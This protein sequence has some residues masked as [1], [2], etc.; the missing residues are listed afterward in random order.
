ML[1]LPLENVRNHSGTGLLAGLVQ[2]GVDVGG[3]G[4]IRVPQVIG[5]VDEGHVLADEQAGEGVPQV[6]EADVPQAVLLQQ[7]PEVVGRCV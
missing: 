7:L 6:V 4:Q 1:V 5:H 3:G 2:V